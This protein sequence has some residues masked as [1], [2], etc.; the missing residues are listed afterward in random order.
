MIERR[1]LPSGRV[2]YRFR[3]YG[4]D[5]RER[6]RSFKRRKDAETY[7]TQKLAEL[8]R[9]DWL[10]PRRGNVILRD[11]WEEYERHG[12]GH[13]REP[14]KQNYRQGWKNVDT[15]LGSWQLS[16][17]EHADVAEWVGELS[18]TKG[19]DTVRLAY[20]VLLRVLD[21]ALRNRR[22][23]VNPA[24]GVLLPRRPPAR[25]RILT[26]VEV[27]DLADTMGRHGDA[28]L[29]MVYLGLR[30][31]ELAALR[32]AD[33]DLSRRRVRVVERATEVGGKVDL[34]AP[35]SR[36]SARHI[37][38]PRLLAGCLER[39]TKERPPDALV[40]ASPEGGYLRNGNWRRMVEWEKSTK[41]LGLGGITPH[42]L[43]RTYGS[44]A[45]MAGADLRFIQKAMGHESITTTA[46]IYAHL[47]D[48]EL[49]TIAE[50][51]DGLGR[52]GDRS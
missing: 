52:G 22:L 45:R 24:R 42:D 14:T 44:L 32:V 33:V 3:Y 8:N 37:P 28:V 13:L 26:V 36:A 29:A 35:K 12:M 15:A 38:V 5:R 41:S 16:R 25:E 31:S 39:R 20:Q 17:I 9:G 51:L 18:T 19:P 50:A 27:H 30:W 4:P 47:Y 43:R 23:A 6:S 49:D 7:A 34:A 21:H 11:M 40:F 1:I 46:R 48:D 2:T 10:D